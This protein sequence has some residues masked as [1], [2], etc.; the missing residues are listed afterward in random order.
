MFAPTGPAASFFNR[1]LFEEQAEYFDMVCRVECYTNILKHTCTFGVSDN[2]LKNAYVSLTGLLMLAFH[3]DELTTRLPALSVGDDS[4]RADGGGGGGGGGGSIVM[5]SSH[6]QTLGG[7]AGGGLY[8]S[9]G[10]TARFASES[11]SRGELH[12]YGT[13][14]TWQYNTIGG[15]GR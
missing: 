11:A 6:L 7:G 3:P 12:S 8:G 9:R 2:F 1:E 10:Q 13:G 4:D 5:S 15:G 14:P